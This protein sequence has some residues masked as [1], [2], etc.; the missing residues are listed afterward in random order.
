MPDLRFKPVTDFLE[1]AIIVNS[2]KLFIGNQSFP[3]A[4][5]EAMKVKRL[6]EVYYKA[7]NVGVQGKNGSEFM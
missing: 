7:P 4:L 3:F 2:C 1:M 6:L 5:A